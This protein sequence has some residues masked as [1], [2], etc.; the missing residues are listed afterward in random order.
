MALKT[1]IVDGLPVETTDAG[2][3]AINK[4]RG[5]L[6][7]AS[8]SIADKDAELA[9][10]D[11]E[12]DDLKAKALSDADLDKRVAARAE[13]IATAKMI[14]KDVQTDGLSDGDIR[15]AVVVAKLGDAAVKD[16]PAAYIDARFDILAEEAKAGRDTFRDAA[17]SGIVTTDARA[18]IDQAHTAM[19][20]SLADAWKGPQ[21]KGAA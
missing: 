21:M 16:K 17:R 14:A 19:V 6:D 11:A 20:A 5:L 4:L 7:T 15:K 18:T 9:K 12:L 8:A 10:K 2:E 13:L 1:I 3:A